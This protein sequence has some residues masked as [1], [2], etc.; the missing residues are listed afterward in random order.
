MLLSFHFMYSLSRS[1]S[2]TRWINVRDGF[3]CGRNSIGKLQQD[4]PNGRLTPAKFVDMYKMF[5]PS[6]NA[7]EFCD[8][9]FRTF[10]MDK[11]G[12]IDFKVSLFYKNVFHLLKFLVELIKNMEFLLNCMEKEK[13]GERLFIAFE[14][15]R[16]EFEEIFFGECF[17]F[18]PSSFCFRVFSSS[19]FFRSKNKNVSGLFEPFMALLECQ[20]DVMKIL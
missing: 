2:S 12:Y 6:G 8:H 7:E 9:V 13:T 15:E 11:N 18:H 14:I 16:K 5:F 1:F 4:C 3:R 10:D 17:L 20:V 19:S